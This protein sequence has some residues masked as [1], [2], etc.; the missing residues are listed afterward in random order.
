MK[1]SLLK[2]QITV[3]DHWR[4]KCDLLFENINDGNIVSVSKKKLN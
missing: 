3:K 1:I 4:K 2:V